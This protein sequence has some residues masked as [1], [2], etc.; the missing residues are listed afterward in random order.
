MSNDIRQWITLVES[1]APQPFRVEYPFGRPGDSFRRLAGPHK[2]TCVAYY[3]NVDPHLLAGIRA[4]NQLR[5][6][7]AELTADMQQRGYKGGAGGEIIVYVDPDDAKIG[8]GNHRLAAALR[9]NVPVDV[10]VRYRNGADENNLLW[11]INLDRAR[12]IDD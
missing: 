5:Y 9:A 4:G 8:E 12:I 2:A 7:P 1:A 3:R 6:N 11:P 10:Q